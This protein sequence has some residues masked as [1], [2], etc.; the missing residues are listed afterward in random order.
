MLNE[1]LSL[2]RGLT[3]GG[4]QA[5]SRHPD[6]SRLLKGDVVRIR[7]NGDGAIDELEFLEGQTRPEIWTLRK[8]K[9]HGFPGLKTRSG[10]ILLDPMARAAH[11]ERW[12]LAKSASAKRAEIARVAAEAVLNPTA[13]DWLKPSHQASITD[14]LANL[15]SLE[16]APETCAVPATFERF[17][18]TLTLSPP[19][20]HRFYT[21]ILER[22]RN[23]EDAWLDVVHSAFVGAIAIAIDVSRG[24]RRDASDER[25]IEGVSRALSE[26]S[27]PRSPAASNER[28]CGL[29]GTTTSLLNGS[30]PQPT[31]PSLGQTYLFSRNKD[32]RAL[33]RYTRNGPS[34][35]PV[36]A[37]LVGRFSDALAT[38]TEE[39]RRGKTWRLL[40]PEAGNSQD[41]FITFIASAVKAD[42]AKSLS[43]DDDDD[44][45][46]VRITPEQVEHATSRVV[47]FWK[48][49]ASKAAPGERARILILRTVDPGNRKSVYD[50]S[51]SVDALYNA[52]RHWTAAM[53][54]APDWISFP[55]LKDKKLIAG[56][57]RSQPPLSLIG[58]SRKFYI[59][60]GREVADAP[61]LAAREVLALFLNE[62]NQPR[63]SHGILNC[64]L[65]GRRPS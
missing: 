51:P 63:R 58:L 52:A 61:G 30:F 53:H 35:M 44:A 34:S 15:R 6:L 16:T 46:E 57:L 31:L 55:L 64:C 41:L 17:L 59:R 7:L 50:R 60:G 65:I 4:F 47:K 25:Q 54:N 28:A 62:G 9:H 40:P 23:G 3:A 11:D 5:V 12:K 29:T 43:D 45:Q 24:F 21:A 13:G 10:L 19:F 48:G 33:A 18:K 36:D 8:G 42:I 39:K 20:L 26:A 2:E 37:D 27:A 14:R 49:L 38:I 1:L 22:A 56:R 32:I